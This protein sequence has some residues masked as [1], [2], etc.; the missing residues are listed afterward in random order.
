[1]FPQNVGI[2]LRVNMASKPRKKGT[3]FTV[4][5]I[6]QHKTISLL[7]LFPISKLLVRMKIFILAK[8]DLH[9]LI[10]FCELWKFLP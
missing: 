4:V 9:I 7:L 1:M 8:I 10:V 3:F 6:S 5:R 2:Y